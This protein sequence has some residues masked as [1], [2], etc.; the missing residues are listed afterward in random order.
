MYT[1]L[2]HWVLDEEKAVPCSKKHK[3]QTV[4]VG[5]LTDP[6][7]ISFEEAGRI[8]AAA[9]K[10][11]ALKK[12]SAE[13]QA[14]WAGY[15]ASLGPLTSAC[16]AAISK[17]VKSKEF[18]VVTSTLF[19][20][21]FTG[22]TQAEWDKG[23]RWVRCNVVA[24]L[25]PDDYGASQALMRLPQRL[26]TALDKKSF[27][28]CWIPLEQGNKARSVACS[29]RVAKRGAWLTVSD[30]I[31]TGKS[32]YPGQK[33]ALDI[34]KAKCLSLISHFSNTAK[35]SARWWTWH[36]KSNGAPQSGVT[37]ATWGT[38]DAHFGCAMPSW[39][40]TP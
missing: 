18:G 32:T 21:D 22:P 23:A 38:A 31:P 11:G 9:T 4:Y 29:S 12:L 16:E 26:A 28:N 27:R 25:V 14:K 37:K 24:Q 7:A 34:A 19:V 35:P 30:L 33:G 17:K 20:P 6:A 3:A 5:E 8:S 2:D 39:E 1:T 36:Q 10:A 40:F 13:D 15:S